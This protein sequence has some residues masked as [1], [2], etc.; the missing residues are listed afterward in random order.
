ME[1][2][3]YYPSPTTSIKQ[4]IKYASPS[5]YDLKTIDLKLLNKELA[6]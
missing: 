2:S 5:P 6:M 1:T 4:E 3:Q